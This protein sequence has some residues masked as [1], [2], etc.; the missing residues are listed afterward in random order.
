[1]FVKRVSGRPWRRFCALTGAEAR[2]SQL[3]EM[4]NL[5]CPR[6]R[7]S[8]R[9]ALGSGGFHASANDDGQ[10]DCRHNGASPASADIKERAARAL[11]PEPHAHSTIILTLH[12]K[13]TA[14]I[15]SVANISTFS[16]EANFI[17]ALRFLTPWQPYLI[18]CGRNHRTA[19]LQSLR[20]WRRISSTHHDQREHHQ[21]CQHQHSLKG[22]EPHRA[23]RFLPHSRL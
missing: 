17:T 11:A 9:A 2:R 8:S 22:S 21:R 13:N 7:Q 16:K 14:N 23:L 15:T 3:R 5:P 10:C 1:M 4:A 18:P 20:A 19:R 12:A 6:L